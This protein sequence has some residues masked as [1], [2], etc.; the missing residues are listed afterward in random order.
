MI[1]K[2]SAIALSLALSTAA[3]AITSINFDWSNDGVV[4]GTPTALYS[5]LG[6]TTRLSAGSTAVAGDG[7]LIQLIALQGGS[8]FVLATTSV[9]DSVSAVGG[10]GEPF[11]GT[12][13]LTTSIASNI[14]AGAQ[15]AVLGVKFFNATTI[16]SATAYGIVSNLTIFTPNPNVPTPPNPNPSFVLDFT[17][18]AYKGARTL[19]GNGF[20]TDT[21]IVVPEP[22][23]VFLVGV[24]LA[25]AWV[26]RRRKKS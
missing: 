3:F 19:S 17:D 18:P 10:S 12:F 22:S 13:D 7:F 15:G 11:N 23:T 16:G 26:L 4:N 2:L 8:N 24:G 20:Y 6:G 25:G 14:L 21:L 9:G 1:K 5:D